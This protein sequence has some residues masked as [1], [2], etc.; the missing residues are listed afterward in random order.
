MAERSSTIP[1]SEALWPAGLWPPLRTASSVPVSRASV[2]TRETSA[3][4]AARTIMAGRRSI[5]PMKT[6]RASS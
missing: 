1:P 6:R 4:S 3:A 5:V 2:M